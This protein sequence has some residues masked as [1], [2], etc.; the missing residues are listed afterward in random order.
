MGGFFGWIF[1]GIGTIIF[2]GILI[3]I[4]F[5]RQKKGQQNEIPPLDLLDGKKLDKMV[6]GRVQDALK[7]LLQSKGY[8]EE[9][10][11]DIL[12]RTSL[13]KKTFRR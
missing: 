2:F 12:T 10:I 13:G 6:E 11:E 8:Q 7:P 4:F 1:G 5:L 9:E 3:F